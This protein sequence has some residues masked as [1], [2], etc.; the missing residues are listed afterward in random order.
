MNSQSL[1][2]IGQIILPQIIKYLSNQFAAN[3]SIMIMGC[4]LL[5]GVIGALLFQPVEMHMKF[6]DVNETHALISKPYRDKI[7]KISSTSIWKKCVNTLDLTLLQDTR[8]VILIVVLACNY[9]ASMDCSLIFPFFLQVSCF[10]LILEL[11]I[12]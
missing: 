10:I 6:K 11:L 2:E 5:N 1:S 4:I 8:F 12:Y 7:D 9:A 3:V